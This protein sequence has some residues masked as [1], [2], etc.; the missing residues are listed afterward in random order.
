MKRPIV[1]PVRQTFRKRLSYV[2][3]S[4]TQKKEIKIKTNYSGGVD[5]YEFHYVI[6]NKVVWDLN[7]MTECN[8]DHIPEGWDGRK[9]DVAFRNSTDYADEVVMGMILR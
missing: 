5:I 3:L 7:Q 2:Q 1:D 8:P 4:H 6:Y 9:G